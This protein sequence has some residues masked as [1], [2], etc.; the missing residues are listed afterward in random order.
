MQSSKADL[1]VR[2]RNEWKRSALTLVKTAARWFF[3]VPLGYY[4]FAL[5]PFD[6]WLEHKLSHKLP[7]IQFR[8]ALLLTVSLIVLSQVLNIEQLLQSQIEHSRRFWTFSPREEAY[9]HICKL[10]E[11]RASRITRVEL[12]Q[13]SGDT[14]IP[15]LKEIA[16][17]CPGATVELFLVPQETASQF[18]ELSFHWNRVQHTK[19]VL[20]VIKET[21]PQIQYSRILV[22]HAAFDCRRPH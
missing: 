11:Q 5:N 7:E 4:L 18:D 15:I 9:A 21:C 13:F 22:H 8:E 6:S 12:L 2:A 1:I 20:K 10:I 19:G 14:A 17:R 16:K 3:W